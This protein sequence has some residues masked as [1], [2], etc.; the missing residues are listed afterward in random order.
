MSIGSIIRYLSFSVILGASLIFSP[1]L[2]KASDLS[3]QDAKRVLSET[4]TIAS[5]LGL[6]GESDYVKAPGNIIKAALFGAYNAKNI[7]VYEQEK[8][9]EEGQKPLPASSPL[10]TV[11]GQTVSA[12][13]V[14][15][16][17]ENPEAFKNRA[18]SFTCFLTR[19]AVE[20]AA[21]HFTGHSVKKHAAPKGD[22][23][24][25]ETLLT[26]KGYFVSIDGLGDAGTEAVLQDIS[27]K[28]EGFLLTGDV[29]EVIGDP[30]EMRKP[31][32]FRLVLSPGEKAGTWKRQYTENGSQQE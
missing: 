31:G 23:F 28:G 12:N 18:E 8:R 21:L 9:K 19:E 20:G 2:C 13:Q 3:K 29:I 6:S 26:D 17:S 15:L 16:R 5:Y 32:T 4:A 24:F 14:L 10:F 22:D 30:E 7:F 25:G 27:K 11:N 1:D